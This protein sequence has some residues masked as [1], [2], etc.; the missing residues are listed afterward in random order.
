MRS[1]AM[2][3]SAKRAGQQTVRKISVSPNPLVRIIREE[4]KLSTACQQFM[5]TAERFLT[6]TGKKD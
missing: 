2:G 1:H 4:A 5:D 6:Y 3:R